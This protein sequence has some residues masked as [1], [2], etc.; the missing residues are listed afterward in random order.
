VGALYLAP[1]SLIPFIVSAIVYAI[2]LP[3]AYQL[4]RNEAGEK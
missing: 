1:G 4:R 2:A 3:F